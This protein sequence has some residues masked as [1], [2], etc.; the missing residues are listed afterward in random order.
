MHVT[1]MLFSR[2]SESK[3]GKV[4]CP[5]L[6]SDTMG[7][8]AVKGLGILCLNGRMLCICSRI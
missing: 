5:K 8:A 2:W 1:K 3:K 7:G 4:T 6:H